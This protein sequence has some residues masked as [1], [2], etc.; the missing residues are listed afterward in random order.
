[1]P[2]GHCCHVFIGN[3][4]Y[5]LE[6]RCDSDLSLPFHIVSFWRY[7]LVLNLGEL[8]RQ[9]WHLSPHETGLEGY[10]DMFPFLGITKWRGQEG[11]H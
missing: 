3:S 6:F 10:A 5:T 1:M 9:Q 4:C 2:R 8:L 11:A 7:L